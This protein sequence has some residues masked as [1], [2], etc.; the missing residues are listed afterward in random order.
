MQVACPATSPAGMSNLYSGHGACCIAI[1][2]R[3]ARSHCMPCVLG[4]LKG[5]LLACAT[6]H[7]ALLFL[8]AEWM[9]ADAC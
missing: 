8:A 2:I 1:D 6:M 4:N 3:I 9:V 7:N 5:S